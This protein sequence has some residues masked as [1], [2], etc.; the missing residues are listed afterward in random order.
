MVLQDSGTAYRAGLQAWG[1]AVLRG[2][3]LDA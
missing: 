1:V 3:I 2:V